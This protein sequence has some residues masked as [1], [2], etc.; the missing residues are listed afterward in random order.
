MA[1][2]Q[3]FRDAKARARARC[4]PRGATRTTTEPSWLAF[5]SAR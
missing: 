5:A 3:L 1:L 4:T 2:I